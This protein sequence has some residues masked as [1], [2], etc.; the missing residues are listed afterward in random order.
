[1]P[2]FKS[3]QSLNQILNV[4]MKSSSYDFSRK[5]L[6][7]IHFSRQRWCTAR[8]LALC[9]YLMWH[10]W[11]E[12]RRLQLWWLQNPMF[13]FFLEL[14]CKWQRNRGLVK[15]K[16]SSPDFTRH[17]R[18]FK[19]SVTNL[20]SKR[21]RFISA[22]MLIIFEVEISRRLKLEWK[23]LVQKNIHFFTGENIF[24]G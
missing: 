15:Q 6:R 22:A 9:M 14:L 13:T 2:T 8:D 1:M 18:F 11:F 7:V 23:A 5:R 20:R 3:T 17:P 21:S 12:S 16:E 24:P 4:Q 19:L 10:G